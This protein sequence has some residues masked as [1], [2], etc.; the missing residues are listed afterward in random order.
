MALW[1]DVS[2]PVE[3]RSNVSEDDLQIV[4]RA[5]YTQVL[6]NQYVMDSDRLSNGESLL[7]N[8]DITV[9]GFVRLVAHSELYRALFF[10]SAAPYRFVELNCRHLLGRAPR[11]QAE[12]S[13][14]VQCYNAE[15]YEAE[16]DSYIDSDEYLSNFGENIVPY[17]CGTQTQQGATNAMFNRSFTLMRGY[18]TNSAAKQSSSLVSDI[19]AKLATKIKSPAA[20]SGSVANTTKRYSIQVSRVGYGPSVNQSTATVIVGYSQLSR[21][22]QNIQKTGGRIVSI[23]EVS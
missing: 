7:R 9:R 5:V 11:D 4:I 14:H 20:G 6:G 3:L 2:D 16:I 17:A 21:R 22:I 19:G 1:I 10:E 15:G 13:E 12:V 18:A 23:T 8:G